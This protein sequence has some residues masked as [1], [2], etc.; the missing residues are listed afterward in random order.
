MTKPFLLAFAWL[1]PKTRIRREGDFDDEEVKEFSAMREQQLSEEEVFR[2]LKELLKQ[3]LEKDPFSGQVAMLKS[4]IKKKKKK[5][6]Y[7]KNKSPTKK[8]K[9]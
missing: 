5:V 2:K 7:W 8:R 4:A 3:E 6:G 9:F 1:E